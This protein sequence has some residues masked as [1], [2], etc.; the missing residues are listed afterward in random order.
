MGEGFDKRPGSVKMGSGALPEF[1]VTWASRTEAPGGKTSPEELL[2]AAH[3]SCYAMALSPTL[4]RNYKFSAQRKSEHYSQFVEMLFIIVV[5]PGVQ[6]TLVKQNLAGQRNRTPTITNSS[7]WKVATLS[8]RR[9]FV[10]DTRNPKILGYRNMTT[11]S[12]AKT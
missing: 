12:E 6:S 9:T 4:A 11:Q 2:A 1:P 5:T 3:A 7:L 10:A 8:T